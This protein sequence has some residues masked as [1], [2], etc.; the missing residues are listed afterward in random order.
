VQ[1]LQP[2]RQVKNRAVCL[3]IGMDAVG[4]KHILG[5]WFEQSEGAKWWL[6]VM[7]EI[8]SRDSNAIESR[9]G[10]ESRAK[11]GALSF[12]SVRYPADMA[13]ATQ[14]QRELETSPEGVASCQ[15][16]ARYPVRC[17]IRVERLINA[18]GSHTH[19]MSDRPA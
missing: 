19:R 11:H 17:A 5:L 4:L 9:L 1:S 7:N 15:D 13:R 6:R 2:V 16:A 14:H 12:E 10:E 3:P 18:N 8:S